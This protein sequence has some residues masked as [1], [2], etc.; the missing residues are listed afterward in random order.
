MAKISFRTAKD[1]YGV[2]LIE[3]CRV[4]DIYSDK[5]GHIE[6]Y[7]AGTTTRMLA[8]RFDNEDRLTNVRPVCLEVLGSSGART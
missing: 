3:G 2:Y 4:R 7:V 1:R 8:V 6:G 5:F